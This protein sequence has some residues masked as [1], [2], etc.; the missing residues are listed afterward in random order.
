MVSKKK[1]A[2]LPVLWESLD[3]QKTSNIS[4]ISA[5]FAARLVFFPPLP[6]VTSQKNGEM[7]LFRQC[8]QA[9]VKFLTQK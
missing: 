4:K 3:L 7:G 8:F 2:I 1:I 9:E 5:P 6:C